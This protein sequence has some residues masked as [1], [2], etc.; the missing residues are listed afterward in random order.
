[1]TLITLLTV[2]LLLGLAGHFKGRMDGIADE[3]I[4]NLDWHEKYDFT[5]PG[6]T[7][8]WW[9]LGLYTPRFPERFPF[10]S[11]ILVFLTDRWHRNQFFMLRCFYF[12]I[13]LLITTEIIPLLIITMIA[14][15]IVVGVFFEVSYGRTRDKYEAMKRETREQS[16]PTT[17][18]KVTTYTEASDESP[19]EAQVTSVPEKGIGDEA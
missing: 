4:K 15:P 17:I 18:T 1:M 12:A 14:M 13:G 2:A 3:G 5:K 19:N 9:Y 16:R 7:K 11:T 10:S 8:H 6:E